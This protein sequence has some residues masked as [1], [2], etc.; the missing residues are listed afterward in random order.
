MMKAMGKRLNIKLEVWGISLILPLQ[1][2]KKG[3]TKK[4]GECGKLF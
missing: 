2:I 3:R 4:R 1:T